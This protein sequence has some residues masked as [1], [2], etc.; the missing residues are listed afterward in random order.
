MAKKVFLS[1]SELARSS[2]W[3][4]V[5]SVNSPLM[6]AL[7]ALLPVEILAERTEP[8]RHASL[9][10]TTTEFP[11]HFD[12]LVYMAP[13]SILLK[14]QELFWGFSRYHLYPYGWWYVPD[15]LLVV[16]SWALEYLYDFI[17]QILLAAVLSSASCTYWRLLAL[18]QACSTGTCSSSGLSSSL[19]LRLSF[20]CFQSTNN[21]S[22]KNHCDLFA[23]VHKLANRQSKQ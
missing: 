8:I 9:A 22:G 20:S 7:A 3:L 15:T 4:P 1:T 10:S 21:A 19:S 18:Q 23:N 6:V 16:L 17:A 12:L 2:P 14:H 5:V 11:S 13:Y